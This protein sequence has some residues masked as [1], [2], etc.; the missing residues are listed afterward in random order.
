MIESVMWRLC[1]ISGCVRR[2]TQAIRS[3]A[4]TGRPLDTCVPRAGRG[5]HHRP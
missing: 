5:V 3:V 4:G 2:T 1:R